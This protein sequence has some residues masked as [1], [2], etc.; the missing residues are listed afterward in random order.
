MRDSRSSVLIS[1]DAA[2]DPDPRVLEPGDPFRILI[3]GDF[4]GRANRG[5]RTSLAGRRP[6]PI[7]R[8]NFDDVMAAVKPSLDLPGQRLEFLELDDFHPDRLYP[9]L[10]K[11]APLLPAPAPAP[12]PPAASNG[13]LLDRMLEESGDAPEPA[14]EFK[15]DLAEFL[16]KVVSP[17]LET[18]KDPVEEL[19]QALAGAS[20][21][22]ALNAILHHADF[23]AL[24]A[25][26]RAALLLVRGLDTDG[27]LRIFLYDATLPE[28]AGDPEGTAKLL[29]PRE[30]W[31]LVVGNYVFGQSAPY[32]AVLGRLAKSAASGGAAFLAE[33]LPP[34]GNGE[35]PEWTALRRSPEARF[36]GLAMPRFLL[37]LPYG[38]E[39]SPV[40][41]ADFEEMPE[42]VHAHYLWGNPAFC[43][44]YLLA[45]GG[46]RRRIEG[47]PLH[48]YREDG[49]EKIK[50]CAEVLLTEQQAEDLLDQG[51]MPLATLKNQ[52][53][54]LV[55]RFQ[56]IAS[57]AAALEGRW[58]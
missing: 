8:D 48:A 10:H 13:S 42:S 2:E 39:T 20:A 27:D 55:V 32:A 24:E 23:Q 18:P 12:A 25:A 9:L 29:A 5:L 6:V 26:W 34:S 44:A 14:P 28:L 56:S 50:P 35:A 43:C 46:V 49:E 11:P 7:D 51:I 37:R 3:A 1:A 19:R 58:G 4:S 45:Q 16:R 22:S 30:P 33:A 57:P 41:S 31:S 21:A 36:V 54:V 53:A 15:G 40:E 17:H 52:D 38:K 47:L